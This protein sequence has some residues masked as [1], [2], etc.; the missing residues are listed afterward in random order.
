[1]YK[2]GTASGYLDLLNIVI[3]ALTTDLGAE[4]WS[5]LRDTTSGYTVDGEII[6]KGTGLAGDDEIFVG[7]KAHHSVPLNYWNWRLQGYTGYSSIYTFDGQPAAIPLAPNICLSTNTMT[8]WLIYNGQRFALVVKRDTVYEHL[9]MGLGFPNTYPDG[10]PY[11]LMVGGSANENTILGGDASINHSAYFQPLAGQFNML[12]GAEWKVFTTS[13]QDYRTQ[14]LGMFPYHRYG[15]M[16]FNNIFSL[17]GRSPNGN[18]AVFPIRPFERESAYTH[19]EADVIADYG[20]LDGIFAASGQG[21]I[22][23]EDTV[24][25][26]GDTYILFQNTFRT[27]RKNF[28]ALKWE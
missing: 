9:Y 16:E 5:I 18:V 11:Q 17:L 4:N 26:G 6:L 24:T 23:S 8:Y 22:S 7:I 19:T 3:T 1:M 2:T 10:Y 27:S 20:D 21:G 15:A 12:V 25:I 28:I 14:R 13:G